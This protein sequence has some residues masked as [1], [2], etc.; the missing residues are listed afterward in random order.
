M[1]DTLGKISWIDNSSLKLF[2]FLPPLYVLGSQKHLVESYGAFYVV[3]RYFNKER[4]R[5]EHTNRY[6]RDCDGPKVVDFK[7]YK[8]DEEWG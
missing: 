7:V 8:L 1:I 6:V 5:V 3:D 4:R 2:P